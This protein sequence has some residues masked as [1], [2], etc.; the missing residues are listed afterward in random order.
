[1][2]QQPQGAQHHPA[3][4][5]QE[6]VVGWQVLTEHVDRA[7]EARRR[8]IGQAQQLVEVLRDEQHRGSA[9]P[10]LNDPAVCFFASDEIESEGWIGRDQQSDVFG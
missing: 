5:H 4:D 1:V 8:A 2:K 10:G 9:V 7:L 6:D 3:D